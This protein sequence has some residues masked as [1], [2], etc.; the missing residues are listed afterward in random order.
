MNRAAPSS[1]SLAL[2]PRLHPISNLQNH[3]PLQ[4]A[5]AERTLLQHAATSAETQVAHKHGSQTQHESFDQSDLGRNKFGNRAAAFSWR[6]VQQNNPCCSMECCCC[7]AA[8]WSHM[9]IQ[10]ET[11]RGCVGCMMRL[12]NGGNAQKRS[13]T[14]THLL[15]TGGTR[16]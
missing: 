13:G 16:L 8:P 4:L 14:G 12:S 6:C 9:R 3:T 15:L 10:A 2:L 11:E 5:S 7:A 1:S